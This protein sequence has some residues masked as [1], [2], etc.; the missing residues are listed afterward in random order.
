VQLDVGE[1]FVPVV[2]VT[3]VLDVPNLLERYIMVM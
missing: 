2:D 1:P 3:S